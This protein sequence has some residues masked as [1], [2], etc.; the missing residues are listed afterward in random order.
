MHSG[1]HFSLLSLYGLRHSALYSPGTNW[2]AYLKS[3]GTALKWG[4][5]RFAFKGEHDE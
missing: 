3:A 1:D 4:R 5:P 2:G